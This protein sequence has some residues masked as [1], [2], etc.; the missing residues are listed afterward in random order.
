MDEPPPSNSRP[1]SYAIA[2]F[3]FGLVSVPFYLYGI[4]AIVA[5]VLGVLGLRQ[6]PRDPQTTVFASTG[7]A[8]GALTFSMGLINLGVGP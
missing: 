4:V 6:L 1:N 2:A 3:V 8:L 5:V 7:I